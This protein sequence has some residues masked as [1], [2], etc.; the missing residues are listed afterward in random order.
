M[1]ANASC[2][3]GHNKVGI[4]RP[5]EPVAVPE[6]ELPVSDANCGPMLFFFESGA[7]HAFYY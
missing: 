6:P 2:G 7:R 1:V 5:A 4:E 3:S